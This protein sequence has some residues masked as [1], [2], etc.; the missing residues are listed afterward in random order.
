MLG[1]H[2]LPSWTDAGLEM[3]RENPR[4]GK[5]PKAEKVVRLGY[6]WP[7]PWAV[8]KAFQSVLGIVVS[9]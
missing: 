2:S 8:S 3:G 4:G 5:R 9:I 6:K 7:S 1:F